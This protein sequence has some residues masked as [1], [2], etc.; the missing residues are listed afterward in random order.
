MGV[1]SDGGGTSRVTYNNPAGSVTKSLTSN[2]GIIL[3]GV[4]LGG[5]TYRWM[6]L[7]DVS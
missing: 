6:L 3:F 4:D 2:T 7:G 5:G 1:S